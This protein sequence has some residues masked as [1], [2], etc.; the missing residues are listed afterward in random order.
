MAVL[1]D[2]RI[3]GAPDSSWPGVRPDATRS[4]VDSVSNY[5][6][7]AA[8]SQVWIV[9]TGE[10]D[11][12][13]DGAAALVELLVRSRLAAGSPS[14]ELAGVGPVFEELDAFRSAGTVLVIAG[15]TVIDADDHYDSELIVAG[16]DP[17]TGRLRGYAGYRG[18]E[19]LGR[20]DVVA[21]RMQV[22]LRR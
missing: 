14:P 7:G 9:G 4:L 13:H 8:I 11:P 16:V 2:L 18:E 20:P 21:A 19:D 5:L 15:Q 17:S 6:A 1:S 3:T 12:R 22:L 10:D